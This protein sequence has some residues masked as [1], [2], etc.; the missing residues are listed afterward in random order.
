MKVLVTGANGLLGQHLVKQLLEGPDVV[1]AT[2]RGASRLPF[3]VSRR[4]RYYETDISDEIGLYEVMNIEKPECVVHAA[5]MTQ[6]DECELQREKC[7]R[8]N[9]QGT[10]N[11]V[12][13]AEETARF[14]IYVSTDFVFDGRQGDYREEDALNP[15][16]WYGFTKMQAE[17]IVQTAEIPWAIVRTCLVYGKADGST[18]SNI[19]SWVK[20]SLEQGKPIKV[21]ADQWRTP[22]YV[23]DLARGIRLI[24]EKQATGI[25]HLSGRDK[26][27][28]YEMA[29]Q[30]AER[31]HLDK[32]LIERVD[33][34][35]FVQPGRRPPKTG[36][37]IEKAQ[38]ELGYEPLSFAEGMDHMFRGE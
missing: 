17:S 3:D 32:G 35:T 11:V 25:Y 14:L 33:A 6:V 23:E 22:T 27:S 9:V 12:S 28:P 7:E 5:A 36:F 1:I 30:T 13:L 2:G 31:F 38:R 34:R 16:S 24:I 29:L 19:V 4:F 37:V 26:L 20:Q 18:R 21:V 10:A 8:I 15:L